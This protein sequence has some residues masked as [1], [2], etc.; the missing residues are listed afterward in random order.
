MYWLLCL[1]GVIAMPRA[2]GQVSPFDLKHKLS[3]DQQEEAAQIKPE[4]S[5]LFNMDTLSQIDDISSDTEK[6]DTA[7]ID[8]DPSTELTSLELNSPSDLLTPNDSASIDSATMLAGATEN[9][10]GA[11]HPIPGSKNQSLFLFLMLIAATILTTLTISSNKS[12]VNNILRAVLNDN[13]L[14]LMYREQKKSGAFHYYILYFVFAV[15]AGL[16]LYFLLSRMVLNSGMPMLWRCMVLVGIIYATRHLFMSYLSHVYSFQKELEQYAF[17][18][19][20]FNIFLGLI[21]LPINVF[22]AFCPEPISTF[23]LYGGL[24]IVLIVY[25]FRQLRGVFISSRLLFNNKFYFLLYLCAV[26]IAPV[27]L[28]VK[29]FG[30]YVS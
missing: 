7:P 20:I 6:N 8:R 12:L 1:A 21:L 23:F 11:D 10:S 14:N 16:F 30:A 26:E 9:A 25:I 13:Y 3:K 2:E 27:L 29:Y 5:A 4:E 15:N 19:L 18:I 22:V 24:A 17:T 28:L